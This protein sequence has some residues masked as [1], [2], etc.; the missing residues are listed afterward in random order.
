[1]NG[2]LLHYKGMKFN[3]IFRNLLVQAGEVMDDSIY[4]DQ[5]GGGD[6]MG[7]FDDENFSVKHDAPGILSMANFGVNSN[8]RSFRI[9]LNPLASHDG[10]FVAFGRVV[11]GMEV[12]RAIETQGDSEAPVI[13]DCGE[14]TDRAKIE[15]L[16]L[17]LSLK[18]D[19]SVDAFKNLVQSLS[20]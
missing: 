5:V 17:L 15:L 10:Q 13:S 2:T 8:G 9:S 18:V 16:K 14:V 19:N 20:E 3:E 4:N 12:V 1:M 6:V 7:Y 11:Q